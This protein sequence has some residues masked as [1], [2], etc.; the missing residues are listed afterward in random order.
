MLLCLGSSGRPW[1]DAASF[2]RR[3]GDWLDFDSRAEGQTGEALVATG[4]FR[5]NG[6]PVMSATSLWKMVGK[7]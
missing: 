3:L 4:H 5:L 6:R 1:I 2:A 7:K